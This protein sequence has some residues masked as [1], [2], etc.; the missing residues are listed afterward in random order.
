MRLQT[1]IGLVVM[2]SIITFAQASDTVEVDTSLDPNSIPLGSVTTVTI[3]ITG[4]SATQEDVLPLDVVL[5]IDCSGSMNRYGNII[6]DVYNVE[7]TT[8]YKKLGEFTINETS[9]VEVMLQTLP[10][11]GY[12]ADVYS[13]YDYFYAYLKN[14]NTGAQTSTKGGYSVVR[15][16][17]LQPGTYEVYAKLYTY[18][19]DTQPNRQFGVELPPKR[20]ELA[21]Q[22]A[23]AFVDILKDNDRVAVVKFYSSGWTPKTSLVKALTTNKNAV[24]RA[25]DGLSAG[26][27]TPLGDGLKKALDHLSSNGRNDAVKAIIVLTDGWWNM[28]CDPINQAERAKNMGIRIYTIGWGG[29]NEEQLKQIAEITGGKYFYASTAEDLEKIYK[30][31]AVELSNVTAENVQVRFE[32]SDDVEYAGGATVEPEMDGNALVWDIGTLS[33]NETWSVSFKVRPKISTLSGNTT[34]NVNT[35]N[36]KVIYKWKDETREVPIDTLSLN[37][38]NYVEIYAVPNKTAVN[39]GEPISID[40]YVLTPGQ[41]GGKGYDVAVSWTS[42]DIDAGE[43]SW[44][45]DNETLTGKWIWTPSYDFV[46]HPNRNRT[47]DVTFLVEYS[48]VSNSTVVDI[49]V[50]DV[51]RSPV[52]DRIEGSTTVN[53][54]G[55]LELTIIAHDPDGDTLSYSKNV[56]FG[57][58]DGNVFRWTTDYDDAGTYTIKFTVSDGDKS[59]SKIVTI[60]VNNVNR[61]PKLTVDPK[62]VTVDE[63]QA[64][65]PITITVSD[66]DGDTITVTAENLPGWAKLTKIDDTTWKIDGTPDYDDAGTYTVTVKAS[67]GSDVVIETV[68]ITVNNVNRAPVIDRIEGKTIYN[69]TE[70]VELTIVAHDPDGDTL[71]YG[72]NV[73][74]GVMDGNVFRWTTDNDDAGNYTITFTVSDGDKSDSKVVTITIRDVEA[75]VPEPE[76]NASLTLKGNGPFVGD[77]IW[78]Y[79]LNNCPPPNDG[80]AVR[81]DAMIK[82]AS[83]YNVTINGVEI[84]SDRVPAPGNFSKIPFVPTS[85]G[86]YKITVWVWNEYKGKKK[87]AYNTTLV[88]VYIKP[89]S[90]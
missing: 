75:E 39:E 47:T 68:N 84:V 89:V 81:I 73:T 71:S 30:E 62:D 13:Y 51:D 35:H 58:M 21:K 24:K 52:I 56:T 36:S 76:V 49:R 2:L 15:W 85:A 61:V 18:D 78:I 60:T 66:E 41:G 63:G 53:E 48:G 37:V 64:M 90:S 16:E 45:F 23:K 69:E 79:I 27:G 55:T 26:G 57:V 31:L 1:L 11:R 29:V 25:I 77:M 83:Y 12:G 10:G 87:I 20:I 9:T 67:D 80:V 70:T 8:S 86:E 33:A 4:A 40:V 42:P 59:D 38:Y 82:K 74:F 22:S 19:S 7:L 65:T 5:V 88:R 34:I 44:T 50:N 17:N 32:L 46:K 28:G 54:N 3:N 72:K 6:T 14:K 43:V